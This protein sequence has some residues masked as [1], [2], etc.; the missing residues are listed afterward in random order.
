MKIITAFLTMLFLSTI[1]IA[2]YAQDASG[3]IGDN[4]LSL[5]ESLLIPVTGVV[6]MY[7]FTGI[8]HVASFI[9]DLPANV[10][11]I[12][13]VV[14]TWTIGWLSSLLNVVL[15]DTLAAFDISSV[16]T[17]VAAAFAMLIHSVT[18]RA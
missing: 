12:L 2:T 4:F 8:K 10:Q 1:S 7:L 9:G 5:V 15:P 6:S 13:V 11:R 16:E 3:S 14:V 18:K 17:A